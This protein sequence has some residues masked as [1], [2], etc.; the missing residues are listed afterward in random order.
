MNQLK[1][2]LK[3]ERSMRYPFQLQCWCRKVC[4]LS[5]MC[6]WI[7]FAWNTPCTSCPASKLQA[8][9]A[10]FQMS[11]FTDK[12]GIVWSA[13]TR[14]PPSEAE[15]FISLLVRSISTES[16]SASL[17]KPSFKAAVVVDDTV[18]P[19]L[20]LS[21]FCLAWMLLRKS[22]RVAIRSYKSQWVGRAES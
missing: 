9:K 12:P 19:R 15:Q 11:W 17:F 6:G 3:I 21:D 13:S 7:D 2:N 4:G 10:R 14:P 5:A 18:W 20:R 8:F 22:V 1:R 16:S